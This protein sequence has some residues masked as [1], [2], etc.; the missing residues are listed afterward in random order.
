MPPLLFYRSC[1]EML[2]PKCGKKTGVKDSRAK[3]EG[4]IRRIRV[5]PQCG[6]EFTTREEVCMNEDEDWDKYKTRRWS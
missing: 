6:M 3:K 4:Y 5:C 2:C 1:D